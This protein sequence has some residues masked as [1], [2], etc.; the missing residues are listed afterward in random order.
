VKL[1]VEKYFS[2]PLQGMVTNLAAFSLDAPYQAIFTVQES[3][4]V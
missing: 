2:K 3:I 4:V 1:I